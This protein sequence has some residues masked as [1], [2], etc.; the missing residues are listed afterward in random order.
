ME[1][2]TGGKV[3]LIVTLHT[4]CSLADRTYKV[5]TSNKVSCSQAVS[6]NK[7]LAGYVTDNIDVHRD[8]ILVNILSNA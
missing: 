6:D 1:L 8:N 4:R 2:S 5:L 3:P 7:E